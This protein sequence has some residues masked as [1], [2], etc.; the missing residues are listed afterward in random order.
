MKLISLIS[1]LALCA[2]TLNAQP[3]TPLHRDINV[4][5]DGLV[6][7][8]RTELALYPSR[9]DALRLGFVQSPY[10]VS[11][12][13]EWDFAFAGDDKDISGNAETWETIK[14]P[15]N[16]E[17]QGFDFPVYVNTIYDFETRNPQPPVLP[18]AIPTGTYRRSFTV[19]ASWDGE[20]YLNVCGAKGGM[21][22]YVNGSYIGY[23]E[24]AKDLA[25]F[26]ITSALIQGENEVKIVITKWSTG[27]YLECMDFWRISGIERDVYLSCEPAAMK[28][29][30]FRISST[31]EDD[32]S[33]GVF[34]MDYTPLEL[35]GS[36]E[37]LDPKGRS[38]LSGEILPGSSSVCGVIKEVRKWS[39][40]TPELYKLVL[41]L[42]GMWTRFDVGFRRLE[43]VGN[44]YLVNGQPVKFKGVNL[45]EHDQFTGHYITR[46]TVLRDLQ[47]MRQHNINGIRTCHY[48]QPRF[49]YELCDS[50]GFYVYSEA[51]VESHGMGYSLDRTLGN[52]PAWYAKH[53]DRILNMYY[54]VGNYPCVTVLSLGNEGGNG[55]NFYNAYKELKA[56][57][58]PVMN[59]P[60]CYER[61]E[62]EWN[63]DCLVPQYPGADWFRKMGEEGSDRP[64]FPSEYAH[65]MGNSTGSLDLQW[66][67][68]YKYPN[69]QGGF[70]W[71]WVDQ[72][73]AATD[74]LGRTYWNYGGDYG[75]DAPS[76][77]NFLCNGIVGPD[78]APH[79]GALEVKHVYQEVEFSA[80]DTPG[81]FRVFNR[82]Y[83]KSLRGY[84]VKYT[85]YADGKKVR[86]G[87]R[88]FR[89][90]AQSEE[91]FK[92]RLPRKMDPQKDYYVNFSVVTRRG[93]VLVPRGYELASDQILLQKAA[94][95][96]VAACGESASVSEDGDRIVMSTSLA[97]VVFD[98]AEGIITSYRVGGKDMFNADFGLR[99]NWWRAP[100]DNDYGCWWPARTQDFK[101]SSKNLSCEAVPADSCIKVTYY[102]SSG[103][104]EDV[105]YTLEGDVLKV[106]MAFKAH[107][108]RQRAIEVPRI[109]FLMRLPASAD[110]FS[111]YGRGPQEN[112][113][114]RN[115]S[116]FVGLYNSSA[117]AE[118]VPYV[119]PQECGHH[120]DCRWLNV[121]PMHVEADRFEFTA[122]RQSIDDLDSEESVRNDYQWLN[123]KPGDERDIESAR[124]NLRR[125]QHLSDIVDRD[126]VELSIDYRQTGIGGYDSWGATTEKERTLWSDRSYEFTF[127]ISPSGK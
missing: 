9:R 106:D 95:A 10:N 40:E 8:K 111:Y 68:I 36:Y 24:D 7:Q 91:T 23:S 87:Y 114:D 29:F 21:Y 47:L 94:K 92:I 73:L 33:T 15:G 5:S 88:W 58:G 125:Q 96:E 124:N 66:S 100:N 41:N 105:V 115:T 101:T 104:V 48:P 84:R 19:P 72:G 78:R 32:L 109:G 67:Y 74:S 63:T 64:V 76:D 25:R 89:T 31:L 122:L 46:E 30:D 4:T 51:N 79:P 85:V 113:W 49:F 126:F 123:R 59:R 119:R 16:W 44:T 18:D 118:F 52:N 120:T 98:K 102:L 22:V 37:L 53:I 99:P 14:V 20:I 26:D 2:A 75:T 93:S 17:L 112:Y 28:D 11:L 50:L 39:A 54:R 13:G 35:S 121:G 65:A 56:L 103:N 107:L 27:S 97:E 34:R 83:F 55:C 117:S 62:F 69:L 110:A 80:T 77:N 43:I 3:Q 57:D 86:S 116:A 45:H 6:Q 42:G 61:A 60:V 82:H 108:T 81:V 1:S 90:P 38:V 12:N 127:C 71:D 70:I